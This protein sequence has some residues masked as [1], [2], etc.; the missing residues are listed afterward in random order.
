MTKKVRIL[1]LTFLVL[2]SVTGCQNAGDTNPI[3]GSYEIEQ[4]RPTNNPVFLSGETLYVP[5]YS[6]IFHNND[7]QTVNLT[8]TL[9]IHNVDQANQIKVIK[10]D[11]YNTNGDLVKSYI[12]NALILRPL[13]TVQIVIQEDDKTGGTGANFIIEWA[14][15]SHA[16]SPIVEAVMVSTSSQQGLVFTTTGK[17]IKTL[18]DK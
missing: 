15:S 2:L 13:Q 9:S 6:S 10:A 8:A 17:V 11:Y 5:I 7:F 1:I 4:T 18:G 16:I 3:R 14:S 12:A